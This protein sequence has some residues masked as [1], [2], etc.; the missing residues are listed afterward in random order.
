MAIKVNDTVVMSKEVIR[1]TNHS[2]FARTFKGVVVAIVGNTADVET[3]SGVRS[4][5]L[6]NLS[7][8]RN[9]KDPR[10]QKTSTLI[11]E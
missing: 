2:E 4:L 8:V 1:R 5:P 11:I 7:V 9:V 3:F 6:A 10:T